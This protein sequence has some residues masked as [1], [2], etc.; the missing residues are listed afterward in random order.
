MYAKDMSKVYQL[1]TDKELRVLRSKKILQLDKISNYN[2]YFA[3]RDRDLLVGQIDQID[4]E[5]QC[6]ADQMRLL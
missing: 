3:K 2:S 1:K 5:I 6:R 4:T